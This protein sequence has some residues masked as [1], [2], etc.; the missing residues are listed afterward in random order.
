M[1][2]IGAQGPLFY[3]GHEIPGHP[4]IHVRFQQG[5]ADLPQGFVN[6]LFGQASPILKTLE[7]SG[8]LICQVIE[9]YFNS[10]PAGS[11]RESF[12]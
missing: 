11:Y 8:E 4:E 6:I 12:P 7:D 10:F 2:H 3:L 9:Q 5:A 1:Q